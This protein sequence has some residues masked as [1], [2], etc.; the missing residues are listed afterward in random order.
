MGRKENLFVCQSC[1]Y[2]SSKWL[3]NCP[4]CGE[5]NSF[6]EISITSKAIKSNKK[7][8]PNIVNIKSLSDIRTEELTRVSS[9]IAELDRVLGG[10]FVDSQVIL[11]SGTPGVGKSTLLLQVASQVGQNV[12]YASGEESTSQLASRATRL[13][14]NQENIKVMSSNTIDDVISYL[15]SEKNI[16]FVIL[17]SI[18]TFRSDNLSSRLG[19]GSQIKE[20]TNIIVEYAKSSSTIFIIV[21]HITK[22]GD[23]AGPKLLEHMVDTVLLLEGDKQY[24]Y[25]LLKAEKNRFGDTAEVGI[26]DMQQK[27]LISVS[28]PGEYF[29]T[30]T[31]E[32][33]PGKAK[34]MYLEGNRPILIEIEAL[35]IKTAFGYP[36]RVAS[37]YNLNR[38]NLLAAVIEKSLNVDLSNHD[39]YLNIVSGLKVDEPGLDLAVSYAI[40]SS[41][42]NK[43][44]KDKAL[45]I[46]EVGLL[47]EVKKVALQ[48][49]RI[50][51]ANKLGY[52]NV[53][54]SGNLKNIKLMKDLM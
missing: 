15:Q 41:F 21:G 17:D 45:F 30:N 29:A 23:I 50:K 31:D 12:L 36:R 46:G 5:W 42:L 43:I 40:Y 32:L 47:G 10:G 13:G 27:G 7:F 35:L 52:K 3:G 22:S 33:L 19:S 11:I 54:S 44:L 1:G 16:K 24:L 53:F 34:A 4:K 48:D 20:C 14:I 18:Q 25:R 38:L 49:K 6:E 9:K 28:N 51:E 26:F 39:I 8:D 37:G 2:E